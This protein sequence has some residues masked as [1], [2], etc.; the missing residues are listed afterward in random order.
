MKSPVQK[1]RKSINQSN[2]LNKTN[3]TNSKSSNTSLNDNN[4]NNQRRIDE[5]ESNAKIGSERDIQ[6]NENSEEDDDDISKDMMR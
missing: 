2:G 6:I 1:L 3:S 4:N 5:S